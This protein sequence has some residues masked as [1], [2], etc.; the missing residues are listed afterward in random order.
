VTVNLL[1]ERSEMSVYYYYY[2]LLFLKAPV[3]NGDRKSRDNPGGQ[4]SIKTV[5]VLQLAKQPV[6]GG[7]RSGNPAMAPSSLS[8]GL[9]PPSRQGILRG[10]IGSEQFIAHIKLI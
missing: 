4:I 5:F 6:N 7:S 3:T 1:I 9:P 2:L 8:M 10:L